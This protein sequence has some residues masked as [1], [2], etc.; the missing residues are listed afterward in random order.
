M[1]HLL[2]LVTLFCALT[3]PLTPA[4]QG[5][6]YGDIP[7][8]FLELEKKYPYYLYVPP[9][10]SPERVWPLI[11]LVGKR[12]EDPRKVITPWLDW[13]R[14]NEF[15][16]AA[17]PNLSPEKD[18]PKKADEWLLEVKQEIL[19]RF[20]VDTAR[21]LLVGLDAGAHYAAYLGTNYPKEF[22]AAALVRDGWAGSFEKIIRSSP[23]PRERISFFVALDLGAENFPAQ[24]A[25]A[26]EFE[27][28]GY[29][30]RLEPLKAGE[31]LSGVRER[32]I[33]WFLADVESRTL[34]RE[35]PRHTRK[36]RLKGVIKDFFEV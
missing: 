7:T 34:L 35:K 8:G 13:A 9:D 29:A 24:E 26:L 36:E 5:A 10:Y 30:V 3:V 15:L 28:K 25:R 17:V 31:D 11:F 1:R 33:Q 19:E 14:Q 18:I 12:G 2:F 32:M 22:S 23:N 27:R 16:V 4:T 21:T 6:F 20:R